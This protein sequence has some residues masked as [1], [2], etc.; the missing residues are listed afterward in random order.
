MSGE[1]TPIEDF[2]EAFSREPGNATE[3]YYPN[4]MI[5]DTAAA[6]ALR[7]TPA[8]DLLGLRLFHDAADRHAAATPSRPT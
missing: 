2:A 4:R 8:A 3:W 1:N 5:L 6:N 7:R